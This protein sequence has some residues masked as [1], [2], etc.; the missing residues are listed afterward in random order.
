MTTDHTGWRDVPAE[1]SPADRYQRFALH[2]QTAKVQIT[3]VIIALCVAAFAAEMALG[4][5]D[6]GRVLFSLGASMPKLYPRELWRLGAAMFLHGGLAHIALNMYSLYAVGPF[7]E[8]AFGRAAFAGLYAASG[9]AGF[10]L[11]ARLGGQMSVGASGAIFGCFAAMPAAFWRL[12]SEVPRQLFGRV[13]QSAA[14]TIGINVAY[15][16]SNPRID[17]WGH[18]GGMLCGAALGLVFPIEA[19]G[20]RMPGA[21]KIVV[22]I[23]AMAT[24]VALLL[25]AMRV[26]T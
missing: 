19:R 22:L 14:L 25:A 12:R 21:M 23:P 10:A 6:D 1:L 2:M 18:L 26:H 3:Y 8:K 4:G 5:A 9:L 24:V 7:V 20:D 11:S 15:G 17:N 16:L 13:M